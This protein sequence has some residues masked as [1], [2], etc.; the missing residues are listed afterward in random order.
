MINYIYFIVKDGKIRGVV[1]IV[2]DVIKFEWLIRENMNKKGNIIYIFD[3]IF[4]IS[5]VI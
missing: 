5:L 2:K 3:S 1:E 4:G